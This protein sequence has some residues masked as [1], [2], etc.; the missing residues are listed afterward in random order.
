MCR[1]ICFVSFVLVLSLVGCAD[2]ANT[3]GSDEGGNVRVNNSAPELDGGDENDSDSGMEEVP[4]DADLPEV[5]SCRAGQAVSCIDDTT[6]TRCN[7]EGTG[8]ETVS[9]AAGEFCFRGECGTQ[10]CEPGTQRCESPEA[11]EFCNASGD[12]FENVTACPEG[13]VCENNACKTLCDLGG[14]GPSY[15]GC[16]Y[17][18]LDLDQYTDP[19]TNPKPDEVPHAVVISNPGPADATMR[20]IP[21]VAGVT[22]NVP[23]PIVP[24]GQARSFTMPRLDVSGSSISMNAIQILAS[25]PVIAHQF[26]PLNNE[27]VY[28]NDASLLLPVT[29][30]G[31]EYYV[32]NWPTQILPSFMGFDYEDQHSYVTVVATEP[33]TTSLLV[34]STATIDQSPDVPNFEPGFARSVTLEFGEV[35]NMQAK[36]TQ[37]GSPLN[38]L[39]GTHIVSDKPVAVF[40][41]HE[42]AVIGNNSDGRDSCCADHLEQQL[43]PV[44]TWGT[45]YVAALSPDRGDHEDLWKIVSAEDGVTVTFDPPQDSASVQLDKGDVHQFY[46][47]QSF[48][49]EATGKISVGQFLVSQQQTLDVIGDPAF[50]LAVPTNQFRED[51]HVLT[52]NGYTRDY[53]TVVRP[54]GVTVNLDGAPVSNSE[55]SAVATSGWEI[56]T[57]Q[58]TPGVHVIEADQPVGLVS[59]GFDSAVS[60]GYPGGLNLVGVD[61][62]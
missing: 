51:Y 1:S 6:A 26:N 32:L 41:G 25:S 14:K 2:D 59:Y 27:S 45:E 40:A 4:V 54:T 48:T 15:I 33:G 39:S 7:D 23:D 22:V 30:L 46:S 28:S 16:E 20:F 9:C 43:F 53:I 8:L 56:A 21:R 37:L 34:T 24:A 55:F 50:I 35:L 19:T 12:G 10:L 44:E 29:A 42:E 49:I 11:V 47:K 57:L 36:N 61:E 18:T 58:V 62:P 60:Y 52:P 3:K 31:R 13:T 17:W 38:D 5:G